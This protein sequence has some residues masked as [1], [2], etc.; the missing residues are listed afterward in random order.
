MTINNLVL[1]FD[2][3]DV[4]ALN[5]CCGILEIGNLDIEEISKDCDEKEFEVNPKK[6]LKGH[7][8]A[9]ILATTTSAQKK[10]NLELSK[11]G[12]KELERAKNPK[13]R[14]TIILWCY[15]KPAVKK[16]AVKY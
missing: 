14:N 1:T 11:L 13:T 16:K 12:F 6:L 10:I 9:L 2:R 4:S 8:V 15:K 7:E 3:Y 5:H